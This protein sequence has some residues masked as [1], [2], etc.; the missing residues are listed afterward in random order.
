MD[1]WME[2]WVEG[3][4]EGW[5]INGWMD[6]WIVPPS[7]PPTPPPTPSPISLFLPAPHPMSSAPCPSPYVLCPLSPIVHHISSAPCPPPL[8]T[9]SPA[10]TLCPLTPDPSCA[11]LPDPWPTPPFRPNHGI[12]TMYGF[13]EETGEMQMSSYFGTSP[14]IHHHLQAVILTHPSQHTLHTHTTTT[15]S[16]LQCVPLLSDAVLVSCRLSQGP[17]PFRPLPR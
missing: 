13:A 6:G 4:M 10:P 14:S 5:W 7:L 12:Q 15:T 1:G 17:L 3:W 9:L 8:C 2:G 16:S 11:P